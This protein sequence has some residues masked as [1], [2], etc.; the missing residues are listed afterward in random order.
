MSGR[1]GRQLGTLKEDIGKS[2]MKH[3]RNY[4]EKHEVC[5]HLSVLTEATHRHLCTFYNNSFS[6]EVESLRH[7]GCIIPKLSEIAG[8][9]NL[10]PKK[11]N[12]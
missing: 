10:K 7:V 1:A 9:W 3:E 5:T 4:R 6:L 12:R 8:L 2:L 11:N